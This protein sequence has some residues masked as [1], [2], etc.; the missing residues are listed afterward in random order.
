MDPLE[1]FLVFLKASATTVAGSGSL[2]VLQQDI[3]DVRGWAGP[4][5]IAKS[6][7]VGRLS[8]GPTG[9]YVVSVGYLLM[10]WW[11][12]VLAL[13]AAVLPPLVVLPLAP[14]V[15]RSLHRPWMAGLLRGVA[16]SSAGLLLAV[17]TGLSL[18]ADFAFTP[19]KLAHPALA[20]LGFLLARSGNLH[21]VVVLGVSGAA[22]AVLYFLGV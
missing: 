14:F 20:A 4:D 13:V 16:L 8:P 19:S 1:F 15:R 11:G 18:P 7:A 6:L 5:V 22:G 21:P 10:G 2:P 9:M 3:V 17:G 12:A